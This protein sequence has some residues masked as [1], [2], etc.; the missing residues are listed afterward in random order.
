MRLELQL[1]CILRFISHLLVKPVIIFQKSPRHCRCNQLRFYITM[2]SVSFQPL[3]LE[4]EQVLL[5]VLHPLPSSSTRAVLFLLQ[6]KKKERNKTKL[7]KKMAFTGVHIKSNHFLR[8][9]SSLNNITVN[10]PHIGYASNTC[11]CGFVYVCGCVF[12]KDSYLPQGI[13]V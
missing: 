10:S 6:H 5:A 11:V 2:T 13:H 3:I 8:W 7:F 1:L 4:R 9:L 12:M